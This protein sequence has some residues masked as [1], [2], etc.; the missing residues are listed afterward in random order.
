MK[1]PI[2]IKTNQIDRYNKVLFEYL[3]K[4]KRFEE[5][6]VNTRKNLSKTIPSNIHKQFILDNIPIDKA[7]SELDIESECYVRLRSKNH[8]T[9]NPRRQELY[10]ETPLI[11][12]LGNEIDILLN[13]YPFLQD[14][15]Q[16]LG[17]FILGGRFL[18]SFESST[19]KLKINN[20]K[21]KNLGSLTDKFDEEGVKI[22][23][24]SKVS[25]K[26]IRDWVEANYSLLVF[27]LRN[28]PSLSLKNLRRKR[29]ER[30]RLVVYLRS[31]LNKQW[32]QIADILGLMGDDGIGE[33]A[34]QKAFE[35]FPYK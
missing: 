15:R 32:N 10:A 35:D 29:F 3:E 19:I 5:L 30:D 17:S 9:V 31:K 11:F 13:E 27:H 21:L 18:I 14:W 23:L 34:L 16:G 12:N 22:V 25:K 8:T 7:N 1:I 28:L 33:D 24:T 2:R 20:R 4:D 26:E 6:I